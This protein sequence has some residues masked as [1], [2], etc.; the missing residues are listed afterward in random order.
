MSARLRLS[1]IG[2]IIVLLAAT[3]GATSAAPPAGDLAPEAV[4]WSAVRER[5]GIAYFL[6]G[7]AAPAHIVRYDM[8]T[9]TRLPD[10]PVRSGASALDV[11]AQGLYLAAGTRLYRYSLDGSGEK[12]LVQLPKTVRDLLVGGQFLYAS[13]RDQN[14]GDSSLTSVD[15]TT[16]LV[17]DSRGYWYPMVGL[18]IARHRQ[19]FRPQ[20]WSLPVRYPFDVAKPGRHAGQHDRQPIPWRLSRRHADVCLPRRGP[21]RRELR[22]RLQCRQPDLQQ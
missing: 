6:Y 5:D 9:R 14:W 8:N 4:T 18:S 7:S 16:G 1:V 17:L 12:L 21:R 3:P 22:H 2:F 13:Q 20:Q 10:I 19:D 11:D 15:K